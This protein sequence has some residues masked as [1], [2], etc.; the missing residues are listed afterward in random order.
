MVAQGA[1]VYA[2]WC[3]VIACHYLIWYEM[4]TS[5]RLFRISVRKSTPHLII[6][7]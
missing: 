6:F 4:G 1:L 5:L 2:W 3:Y 7:E